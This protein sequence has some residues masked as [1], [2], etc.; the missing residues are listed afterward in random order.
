MGPVTF[1]VIKFVGSQI[2]IP[3]PSILWWHTM[4][5]LYYVAKRTTDVIKVMGLKIG[6]LT[7]ITNLKAEDFLHLQAEDVSEEE[8]KEI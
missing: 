1:Q 8:V 7:W 6:R 5:M 3:E 4:V 2:L